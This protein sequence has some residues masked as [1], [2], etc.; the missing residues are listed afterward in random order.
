[1]DADIHPVFHRWGLFCPSI[2]VGLTRSIEAD[3][4]NLGFPRRRRRNN[5]T[6][7]V[8]FDPIRRHLELLLTGD[9]IQNS[10]SSAV[11]NLEFTAFASDL[12]QMLKVAF[13]NGRD[14][15]TTENA[16]F[17]VDWFL[18]A[19]LLCDLRAGSCKIL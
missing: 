18:K 19:I 17:K 1:M 10:R 6:V 16:N 3:L 2:C 14:V 11:H 12:L 8:Q 13:R 15:A 9:T 4:G 5:L 7:L